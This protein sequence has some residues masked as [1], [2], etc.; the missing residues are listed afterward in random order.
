[1]KDCLLFTVGPVQMDPKI[2][3]IGAQQ[4]P[5]FRTEMFSSFLLDAEERFLA[6]LHAPEGSRAVFLSSSGTGGMEAVV[7]GLLDQNDRALVIDGGS[8]GHRFVELCGLHGIATEVL[9]LSPGERLTEE[10][11]NAAPTTGL[12]ALLV[13]LHETS[14][15]TLYELPMLSRYCKSHGLLLLIDAVSAFI[16]DEID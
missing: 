4:P 11:L 1:M 2:R 9:S 15:G 3:E 8:F 5:Y 12:T 13:N 10:R 7:D 14:T 16:A 6:L